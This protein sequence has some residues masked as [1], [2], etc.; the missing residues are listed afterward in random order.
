MNACGICFVNFYLA[1]LQQGGFSQSSSL[2]GE[3]TFLSPAEC[4]CTGQEFNTG[5]CD[6]GSVMGGMVPMKQGPVRR[7]L[8]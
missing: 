2:P 8:L 4:H 3:G 7:K 6:G 1:G 5:K